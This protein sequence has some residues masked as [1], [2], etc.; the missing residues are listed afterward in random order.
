MPERWTR[1]SW[2]TSREG[3]PYRDVSLQ[4]NSQQYGRTSLSASRRAVSIPFSIMKLRRSCSGTRYW[5][6][7]VLWALSLFDRIQFNI[8]SGVTKQKRAACPVDRA[9]TRGRFGF[10]GTTIL[11]FWEDPC[12]LRVLPLFDLGRE[13][14]K[15]FSRQRPKLQ[16][17]LRQH[18]PADTRHPHEWRSD[19]RCHP[20]SGVHR[21]AMQSA[22]RAHY[23]VAE[24]CS[25]Y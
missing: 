19:P 4:W 17:H 14:A 12:F 15:R 13:H 9:C 1:Q 25:S 20:A 24:C 2:Q 11:P 21:K 23:P 6:P 16:Q 18:W 3:F 7:A 22:T 10:V 5:P 8:V